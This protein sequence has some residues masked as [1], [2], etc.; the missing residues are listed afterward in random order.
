MGVG[1]GRRLV[2]MAGTPAR[3]SLFEIRLDNDF[4][5]FRGNEEESAGQTVR[6]AVVLCLSGPLRVEDIRVRLEGTLRHR[7]AIFTSTKTF[8]E[9]ASL[10]SACQIDG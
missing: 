3:Y 6:G 5:V 2:S 7:Y 9:F 8:G 10:T 4:V 1:I